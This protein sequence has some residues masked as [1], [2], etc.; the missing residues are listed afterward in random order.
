MV[1]IGIMTIPTAISMYFLLQIML[2]NAS[3]SWPAVNGKLEKFRIRKWLVLAKFSSLQDD[4]WICVV[5][6]KYSYE[7]GGKTYRSRRINFGMDSYFTSPK[8]G[9]L[10]PVEAEKNEMTTKLKNDDF[11]VHYSPMLPSIAVIVPGVINL[12]R[13]YAAIAILMTTGIFLSLLFSGI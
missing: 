12:K 6:V 7:V 2:G 9:Y 10:T 13:H 5:S 3:R 1:I 11:M 8:G 4:G